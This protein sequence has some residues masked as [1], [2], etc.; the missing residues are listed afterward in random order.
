MPPAFPALAG[1]FFTTEPPGKPCSV[2]TTYHI[3]IIYPLDCSSLLSLWLISLFHLLLMNCLGEV[4][5]EKLE[6]GFYLFKI[7]HFIILIFVKEHS[8]KVI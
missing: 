6:T 4:A 1:G 7:Y 2:H 8:A 5:S 3:S